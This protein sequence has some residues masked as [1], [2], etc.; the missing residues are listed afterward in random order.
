M[1]V[2]GD[3]GTLCYK[4]VSENLELVQDNV[5]DTSD[6]GWQLI[7]K[8]ALYENHDQQLCCDNCGNVHESAYTE[9]VEGVVYC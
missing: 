1:F 4:C 6:L 5:E 7:S 2:T 3:G 8:Y 9:E